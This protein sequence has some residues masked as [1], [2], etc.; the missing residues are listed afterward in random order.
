MERKQNNTPY[1]MSVPFIGQQ[2]ENIAARIF[3]KSVYAIDVKKALKIGTDFIAEKDNKVYVVEVK[4]FTSI[5]YS[6]VYVLDRAVSRVI[7]ASEK[8]RGIPVLVV[9]SVI[10]DD[11][12]KKY[13]DWHSG[14]IILDLKNLLYATQ[15]TKIQEEL[16]A[17]L[18]FS[19]DSI[20]QQ[21]CEI[22]L[23]WIEHSDEG[24]ELRI[25][26]EDCIQGKDGA[27]LFEDICNKCLKYIFAD[28]L[29]LWETQP[30]SN[31]G[32]YRFDLICR[33][34]DNTGKTVW[35]II[36]KF[37]NTKYVIFEFKNY[38]DQISQREV[39]TT[40]KYLYEKALRKVAIII[41]RNGY[42][43]N[44]M[45]AA[46][47]SLREN[48][49]LIIFISIEDLKEMLRRKHEQEDPSEVLLNK[50]DELLIELEK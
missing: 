19:I 17:I 41:A 31:K 15:G 16:T 13:K 26:L 11:Q 18:P 50:I 1:E 45:W 46:K 43:N 9:F 42:D 22:D 37:F 14:L 6:N 48:G 28:D 20:E 30:K 4:A 7:N 38:T 24:E 8:I 10:S 39:Y 33:I 25:Q 12:K 23:G 27:F 47:G 32:L 40:E 44:A 5:E 2:L 36:E 34:K 3:E 29:S 49:K 21:Q 35:T